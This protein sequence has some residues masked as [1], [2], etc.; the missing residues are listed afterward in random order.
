VDKSWKVWVK[1]DRVQMSVIES[2]RKCGCCVAKERIGLGCKRILIEEVSCGFAIKLHICRI[3]RIVQKYLPNVF[4]II[5]QI[6]AI[7]PIFLI[8]LAIKSCTWPMMLFTSNAAQNTVT[9][10]Q[11]SVGQRGDKYRDHGQLFY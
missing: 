11:E 7:F 1:C 2:K 5:F 10:V 4:L 9:A 8:E 6:F 3:N